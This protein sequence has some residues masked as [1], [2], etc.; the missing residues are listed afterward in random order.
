MLNPALS[1]DNAIRDVRY[2]W[3]SFLRA[4][5]AS[6]TIVVTVGLGPFSRA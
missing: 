4:P 3:R 1:L 6:A 5:L 2:A